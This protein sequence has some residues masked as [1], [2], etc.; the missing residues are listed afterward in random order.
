MFLFYLD[1]MC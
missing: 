1:N